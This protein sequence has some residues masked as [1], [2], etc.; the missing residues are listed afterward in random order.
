MNKDKKETMERRR[1][2]KM[3]V[4]FTGKKI[5]RVVAQKMDLKLDNIVSQKNNEAR[6]TK[7]RII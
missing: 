2:K 7:L 4:K 1:E 5:S 3:G 6:Q